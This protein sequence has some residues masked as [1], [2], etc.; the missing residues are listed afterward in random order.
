[1]LCCG[2]AGGV[3]KEVKLGDVIIGDRILYY[4]PG[5]V[6]LDGTL[7]DAQ[8]FFADPL[9]LD[10]CSHLFD[11]PELISYPKEEENLK[12]QYH[13]GVIASGEK[14][15]ASPSKIEELRTKL[16]YHIIG[17]EK[18]GNGF[19]SALWLASPFVRGIVIRGVS[20]YAGMD[21][22]D[23][24]WMEKEKRQKNAAQSAA[25]FVKYLVY[26]DPLKEDAVEGSKPLG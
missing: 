22:V 16:N 26:R 9:L 15:I 20:D 8:I 10:R 4:E 19:A 1:M 23:P 11:W 21:I 3:E 17:I 13:I 7:P 24:E 6:T 12:P 14:T 5:K 18:E 2:I 25:S